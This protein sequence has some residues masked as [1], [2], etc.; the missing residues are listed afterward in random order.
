MAFSFLPEDMT[1][2]ITKP[3]HGNWHIWDE[4][5]KLLGE[6]FG[7]PF[8][9][10]PYEKRGDNL[11]TIWFWPK[12]GRNWSNQAQFY[13]SRSSD[14]QCI[15]FGLAVECPGPDT[16]AKHKM[17]P[18]RDAARFIR[19]LQENSGTA[20]AVNGLLA[21]DKWTAEVVRWLEKK[22]IPVHN[23]SEILNAIKELPEDPG[24]TVKISRSLSGNETV[25]MKDRIGAEILSAFVEVRPI[26]KAVIPNKDGDTPPPPVPVQKFRQ[27]FDCR[28]ICTSSVR[29]TWTKQRVRLAQRC[30][31]VHSQ[32]R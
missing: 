9:H 16:I 17:D 32:S 12:D 3:K 13:F 1:K 14:K 22:E 27:S 6:E 4:L 2:Y 24:Y 25:A 23:T 26:W 31:T 20:D 28:R 29:S 7:V 18:D 5:K 10:T 15:Y 8:N 11:N 30:L 19:A 21:E